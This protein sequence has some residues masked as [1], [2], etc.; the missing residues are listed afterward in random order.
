MNQKVGLYTLVAVLVAG[1]GWTSYQVKRSEMV[2]ASASGKITFLS[3]KSGA[4]K[5]QAPDFTLP[6]LDGS[7]VSLADF[8]CKDVVLLEFSS[9]SYPMCRALMPGLAELEQKYGSKGLKVITVNWGDDTAAVSRFVKETSYKP[10]ILLDDGS[11]RER[12]HVIA[13][14]TI[15]IVDKSGEIS[16]VRLGQVGPQQSWIEEEI[17]KLLGLKYT[18][19]IAAKSTKGVVRFDQHN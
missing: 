19:P 12:Y 5:R 18:P 3:S 15:V 8:A 16:S 10:L 13:M 7:K 4:E 2:G 11:V 14:P 1:F 17:C 9:V 6:A